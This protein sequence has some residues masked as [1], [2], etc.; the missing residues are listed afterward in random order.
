MAD[1]T[2]P[3][4]ARTKSNLERRRSE[5]LLL[6]VTLVVRGESA[7]HQPFREETFTISVNAHGALLMLAARVAPGQTLTL[8][9]PETHAE[10]EAHVARY[11]SPHGGLSQVAIEF[12]QPAPE[13]AGRS[14]RLQ[15]VGGKS[16]PA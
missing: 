9:N 6:D 16:V 7:E 3:A 11:G 4:T 15:R 13:F 2:V 12:A 8:L 14:Q 10:R 5:R 1:Q